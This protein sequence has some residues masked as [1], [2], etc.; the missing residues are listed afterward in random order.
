MLSSLKAATLQAILKSY[1]KKDERARLTCSWRSLWALAYSSS[2]STHCPYN[3]RLCMT[4][5]NDL[6]IFL[7]HYL[8]KEFILL[9]GWIAAG[10]EDILEG[11]LKLILGLIWRLILRYQ[12][13]RR[14]RASPKKLMLS[15]IN[16][17]LSQ[18]QDQQQLPTNISNF[19]TDWNDGTALLYVF[20]RFV[21]IFTAQSIVVSCVSAR[22][23]CFRGL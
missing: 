1:K 15:W 8:N 16:A 5:I 11:N 6:K 12:I 21:F 4:I 7:M 13:A 19:T 17:V 18:S 20:I 22:L 2:S 10:A 9:T 3:D 14:G 23:Y